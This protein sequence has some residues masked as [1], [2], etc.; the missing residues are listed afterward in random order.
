M[1]RF[2]PATAVFGCLVVVL[3]GAAIL[4]SAY[5]RSALEVEGLRLRAETVRLASL[6]PKV[7]ADPG[8][9]VPAAS[10]A[11]ATA[12]LVEFVKATVEGAGGV[13]LALQPRQ[14]ENAGHGDVGLRTQFVTDVA[15]LQ[16]A[17]HAI[18]S[19]R[20][21]MIVDSVLVR[22]RPHVKGNEPVKLDVTLEVRAFRLPGPA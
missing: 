16:K 17:M 20:P 21:V 2:L 19:A 14:M 4:F 22:G 6:L 9:L 5:R 1:K 8:L 12:R 15:G 11:A 3:L 18:E 10:E 13:V 7:A